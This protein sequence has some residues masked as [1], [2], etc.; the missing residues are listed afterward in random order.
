MSRVII[1]VSKRKA[2]K[3]RVGEG[4]IGGVGGVYKIRKNARFRNLGNITVKR[5]DYQKKR[6]KSTLLHAKRKKKDLESGLISI[7][8]YVYMRK[9]KGGRRMKVNWIIRH[10]VRGGGHPASEPE[11]ERAPWARVGRGGRHFFFTCS[12]TKAR[13]FLRGLAATVTYFPTNL[14]SGPES[15]ITVN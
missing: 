6:K 3:K 11:G 12:S 5:L 14:P 7:T 15:T 1:S 8:P 13:D 10:G 4:W 2:R 9:K